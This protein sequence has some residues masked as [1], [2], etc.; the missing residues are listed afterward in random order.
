MNKVADLVLPDIIPYSDYGGDF[1]QFDKAVYERFQIDFVDTRPYFRGT[2]LGLKVLPK[3]DD[4]EKTYYHVTH[5]GEDEENRTPDIS[6]MERI[7]YIKFLI[8]NCDHPSIKVWENKRGTDTRILLLCEK[9][10]YLVVLTK[11]KEYVLLWT[12]YVVT[13]RRKTKLLDEYEAYI[14]ANAAQ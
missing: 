11:R 2:R 10:N 12:A 1:S 5:E 3:V 7:A 6:R 14:K 8:N 4:R 9:E 13:E